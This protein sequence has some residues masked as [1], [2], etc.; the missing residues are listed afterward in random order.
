MYACAES[1]LPLTANLSVA[2]FIIGLTAWH[3]IN[4]IIAVGPGDIVVVSGGAGA[5]GSLAGQLAKVKGATVIGI[6]GGSEKCQ[7]LKDVLGFDFAIDYKNEDVAATLSKIAPEGITGYFDNVGGEVT[8]AVLANARNNCRMAFCGSISEYND[9]W[10]GIK[11]FNMILMRRILVQGFIVSDHGEEFGEAISEIARLVAA[12][13]VKY[14]ED[15]RH[16]LENYPATLRLLT[17]GENTGKLI[18]KV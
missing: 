9:K 5:V 10:A 14:S 1:S 11:N 12:G 6:A 4:K 7:H 16:G 17:S 2:S 8:D 15:I 18:L 3:G 13:K